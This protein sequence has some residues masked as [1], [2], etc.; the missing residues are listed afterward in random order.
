MAGG[1]DRRDAEQAGSGLPPAAEVPWS[2]SD[3]SL[4]WGLSG[5]SDGFGLGS[6]IP[7]ELAPGTDLGGFTIGR[8]LGEGGMGRVYEARQATP[9]R[10]VAVKVLR[11]ALATPEQRFRF[12]HESEVLGRLRHPHI[13][14]VHMA[15][16]HRHEAG[17][18]P[19]VVMELIA[20]AQPLTLFV[21]E[22]GLGLRQ[23][24][25][26]ARGVCDAVAHAHRKG[27]IHRDLK[28]ANIL[29]DGS[30]EP[31]VIDFGVARSTA[32]D[33]AA[34]PW[35]T[36]AGQIVG[37]LMYMS[38]EQLAGRVDEIDARADVYALGI[39]LHELVADR[40]PYDSAET[41][42]VAA[43][44]AREDA[45]LQA[46]RT[47]ERATLHGGCDRFS[48][49]ALAAVVHTCLAERPEQRYA[50][51]VEVTAELDRWLAGEP[52]LARPPTWLERAG[53][54][55]R[56]HRA[57]TAA[58]AVGIAAVVAA[59]VGITVFALRA[60]EQARA[61]R[62]ELYTATLQLAADARDRDRIG[63]ARQR[64]AEARAL[65]PHTSREQPLELACLAAS[66]DD[67]FAT[68][69]GHTADVLAAAWSPDGTRLATG[70]RKGALRM[71]DA[72]A[73]GAMPDAAVE[74][75]THDAAVWRI[76]WSPD[77][78]MLA[79][80]SEDKAVRLWDVWTGRELQQITGHG[81][82]MYGVA[83]G[84][85]GTVVATSG[86]DHT[87]RLWDVA[88]GAERVVL[89]GHTG[90]VFS[91]V[92]SSDGR[93]AL[94]ASLDGTARLWD[95]ESGA[96]VRTFSGHDDWVFDADFAPDGTAIAT[97]SQDGTVRLWSVATGRVEATFAHPE[98]VNAVEFTGDGRS[99][100]TA[101]HDGVLRIFRPGKRDPVRQY[102]GHEGAVW[103]VASTPTGSRVA[104]GSDDRTVRLWDA[105][106]R[107]APEVPVQSAVRAAAWARDGRLLA[108]GTADSTI[109]LHD[110][111]TLESRGRIKV[112]AGLIHDVAL[113]PQAGSVFAACADGT[114]RRGDVAGHRPTLRIPC[115]D[116]AVHAVDISPDGLR[117]ATA[118]DDG[119]ATVRDLAAWETALQ[120]VRHSRRVWCVRFAPDGERFY[121]AGDDRLAV[122][123]DVA[124]G[125]R[126]GEF[127]GH[128]AA[129]KWLAVAADGGR[130]ATAS[131]DGT[132]GIWEV[133]TGNLLHRLRGP[134]CEVARVAFA[135]DG[136]RV[137]AVASDGSAHLWDA[138]SG[139]SLPV[140]RGSG[141]HSHALAVSPD[142]QAVAIAAGDTTLRVEGVS[143]AD[144][145]RRR[146]IS[147]QPR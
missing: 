19:F 59:A 81:A 78:R 52:V 120:P 72:T 118:S 146:A 50:T 121:T 51:A 37:T 99:V 56:R 147:P 67:S 32:P 131:A 104:T 16:V 30:G 101:C 98:R 96:L 144:I 21:R 54:A 23:R 33:A 119:T 133:R 58:A 84:P 24:I 109:A 15:G 111:Q 4:A 39:V 94:T 42:L 139:R 95:A 63:E 80:A 53:R 79:T 6:D 57:A 141:G 1:G 92:L 47:V 28:P 26:L 27:V 137:V 86:A 10:L 123:W 45:G 115:H 145:F 17:A 44:R 61:A 134:G 49:R 88:T 77:G 13:A 122:A 83:F 64:L 46:A 126:R 38:P 69:A 8:L 76:A 65:A 62:V 128:E 75:S 55:I 142:G 132:V 68:L 102:H 18:V 29:V 2:D 100:A 91:V 74:F 127:V 124:T 25:E 35:R 125:T 60:S 40:L 41:S 66:L 113:D 129:V 97:A 7:L 107:F 105:S 12:Q 116:K 135:A 108:I 43:A 82:K 36:V 5:R 90:T 103:T 31:K 3:D 20:N 117:L 73:L 34:S 138:A 9:D 89:A 130:L 143:A 14:Q 140:L 93:Q 48:A 70:D 106:G 136:S 11:D 87:A 112:A 114:V 71:V 110:G 22:R 85:D